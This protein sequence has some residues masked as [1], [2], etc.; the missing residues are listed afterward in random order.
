MTLSSCAGSSE[1]T[2][3]VE[4][5]DV[6]RALATISA[7]TAR[8][9]LRLIRKTLDSASTS[10]MLVRVGQRARPVGRRTRL[11]L[12]PSTRRPRRAGLRAHLSNH[13]RSGC[14]CA[15]AQWSMSAASSCGSSRG[16]RR[17]RS[18]S[19]DVRERLRS[20][21]DDVGELG[22]ARRIQSA[23]SP[24]ARARARLRVCGVGRATTRTACSARSLARGREGRR[25]GR[26]DVAV[27]RAVIGGEVLVVGEVAAA[28][29][30]V[31]RDDEPGHTTSDARGG[32][33][34]LGARLRLT[35]DDHQPEP[36]DVD[37]DRDHVGG[38]DDICRV[39][40]APALS[41]GSRARAG[42]R[43]TACGRSSRGSP[44]DHAAS[45]RGGRR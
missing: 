39:D 11:V 18:A 25:P 9:L 23:A 7:V 17:R 3:N 2:P 34:V 8:L 27:Q 20:V 16:T 32:L 41:R 24:A 44:S 36:V 1:P 40:L 19:P 45:R 29:R 22:R 33:D 42:S 38:Q 37:A 10:R 4:T 5:S 35:H 43:R 26:L 21:H 14:R 28:A 13:P 15:S 6:R 30:V 12:A 31:H